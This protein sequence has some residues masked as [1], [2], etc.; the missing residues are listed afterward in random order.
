MNRSGG[1]FSG[2]MGVDHHRA[3]RGGHRP[4]R[5]HRVLGGDDRPDHPGPGCRRR[6]GLHAH[7]GTTRRRLTPPTRWAREARARIVCTVEGMAEPRW[8]P[9]DPV[10]WERPGELWTAGGL[11]AFV[12][13]SAGARTGSKRLAVLGYLEEGPD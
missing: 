8:R 10:D 5:G 1:A 3:G 12:V 6:G 7:P 13:E 9:G 4:V 11:H 2:R